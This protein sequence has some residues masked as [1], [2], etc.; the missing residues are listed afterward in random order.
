MAAFEAGEIKV[1]VVPD[2]EDFY[3]NV[4]EYLTGKLDLPGNDPLS[5]AI[6]NAPKDSF[7]GAKVGDQTYIL[8][9][10]EMRKIPGETPVDYLMRTYWRS[11]DELE[12]EWRIPW[13]KR[14]RIVLDRL[15]WRA[16]SWI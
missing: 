4:E 15:W 14:L 6:R 1:K 2:F 9:R 10:W 3:A 11:Q 7:I 16:T 12:K 13:R 5:R 8:D